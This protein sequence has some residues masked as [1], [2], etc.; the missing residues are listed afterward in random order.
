VA[1][2]GY[3]A[4]FIPPASLRRLQQ[5]AVAFDLGQ[6]FLGAP[7]DGDPEDRLAAPGDGQL[8]DLAAVRREGDTPEPAHGAGPDP[9]V[10]R[11]LQEEDRRLFH[12]SRNP[13]TAQ[14]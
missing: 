14:S 2:F 10:V 12:R 9:V 6:S 7:V 8:L 13:V 1:G 11:L 4:A 5:R 3:L